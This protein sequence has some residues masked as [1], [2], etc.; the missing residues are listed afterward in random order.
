MKVVTMKCHNNKK[1]IG[2]GNVK[3]A[4]TLIEVLVVTSIT[5]VLVALLLPALNSAREAARQTSCRNNLRQLALAMHAHES[6][7]QHLPSAYRYSPSSFG[8]ALG[9]SWGSALL[10]YLEE[11]SLHQEFD[12]HAPIFADVNRIPRERHLSQFVCQ[13]DEISQSGFV[14][15]GTEVYAMASYVA[16][17]GPPDLDETQEKNEGVFSRNSRTRFRQISDGLSHTLLIGER[18]NGPFRGGASHGNHFEYETTW[19]GAVRDIEDPMDDHGHMVL[20]QT[21]HTP[22]SP[23]S[24]DRDV[25]APHAAI[26]LFAFCDGSVSPVS[27]TIDPVVYSKLGTRAGGENNHE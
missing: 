24:D 6:G 22:N 2:H 19:A 12:F 4:F 13:S 21:G 8:N 7:F 3:R 18:E 5:G 10:P 16:N 15:M 9:F 1:A 14:N 25:S 20:F 27:E 26:A 11:A 17:F 23:M